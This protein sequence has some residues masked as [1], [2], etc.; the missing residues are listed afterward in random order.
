MA[1]YQTAQK[2]KIKD[3]LMKN[4]EKDFTIEE[5][6]LELEREYRDEAPG[7]STVYRLVQKMTEDGA[8][9]RI[10]GEY[11]RKFTYRI[12][13][14]GNCALHLHMKCMDCGRLL[15]MEDDESLRLMAEVMKK[16][17]F[18]VD[19]RHTVLVGTCEDCRK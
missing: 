19:E 15:H 8:V 2:K 12:A 17:R 10:A 6:S 5:L 4:Y 14:H 9:M 16:N 7:K 1:S 11:N 18:E 3:F 13:E